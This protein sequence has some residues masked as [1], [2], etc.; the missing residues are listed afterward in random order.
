MSRPRVETPPRPRAVFAAACNQRSYP[1][2]SPRCSLG[3]ASQ[4]PTPGRHCCPPPYS[5][6][7]R[8]GKSQVI[9]WLFAFEKK[10]DRPPL[11]RQHPADSKHL[12]RCEENPAPITKH[13]HWRHGQHTR[14]E[15]PQP[16][17]QKVFPPAY[18]GKCI[19]IRQQL[20]RST[21]TPG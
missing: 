20:R 21:R 15:A 6:V 16:C 13:K 9:K 19:A 4:T 11:S 7:Y 1:L 18:L 5:R 10:C 12:S 14:T 8:S 2:R 17:G 3:R